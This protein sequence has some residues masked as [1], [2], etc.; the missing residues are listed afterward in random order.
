MLQL[1]IFMGF[2][3]GFSKKKDWVGGGGCFALIVIDVP[4]II[5]ILELYI[6]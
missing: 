2:V 3:I 5:R 4:L 1:S 6:F